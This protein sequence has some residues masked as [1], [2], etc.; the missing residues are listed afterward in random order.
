MSFSEQEVSLPAFDLRVR[1]FK[2]HASEAT[3]DV[4]LSTRMDV[5]I[6]LHVDHNM[7]VDEAEPV[8][9]GLLGVVGFVNG[10]HLEFDQLNVH[11][12]D[13]GRTILHK[14]G[15]FQQYGKPSIQLSSIPVFD[16]LTQRAFYWIGK[17]EGAPRPDDEVSYLYAALEAFTPKRL[18][19]QV[20][21]E[22]CN[23]P[24]MSE[25]AKTFLVEQC[26]L[27]EEAAKQVVNVRGAI[28]HGKKS[29]VTHFSLMTSAATDL[30]EGLRT[31][32]EREFGLPMS[33]PAIGLGNMF[34]VVT[35]PPADSKQ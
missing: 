23:R 28:V 6:S 33:R 34:R 19:H 17:A 13:T 21:C 25:G 15:R 31:Y 18:K 1:R 14:V 22:C 5:D 30:R 7:A 24:M 11:D 32:C 35:E 12:V 16:K 27:D 20:K 9:V 4:N 10:V 2:I 26:G 29:A 8:V 3:K